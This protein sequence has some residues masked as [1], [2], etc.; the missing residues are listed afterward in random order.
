MNLNQE[1]LLMLLGQKELDLY[2]LRHQNQ[3]I[4]KEVQRLT[5]EKIKEAGEDSGEKVVKEKKDGK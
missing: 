1:Q 5:D 3:Q 2:A 4:Q